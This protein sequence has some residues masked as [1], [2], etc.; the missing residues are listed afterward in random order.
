M[1][2]AMDNNVQCPVCGLVRCGACGAQ[3]DVQ[4]SCEALALISEDLD[5]RPSAEDEDRSR[6]TSTDRCDSYC[7]VM[8]RSQKCSLIYKLTKAT[9]A[10]GPRGS[11]SGTELL[12]NK[13]RR[14]SFDPRIDPEG[15]WPISFPPALTWRVGSPL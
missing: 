8:P 14:R 2:H 11:G 9:S 7:D 3:H 1:K 10:S 4:T 12:R 5:L 13:H 15:F 6:S